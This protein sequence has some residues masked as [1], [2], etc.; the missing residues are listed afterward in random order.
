V[1]R[2]AGAIAFSRPVPRDL[3]GPGPPNWRHGQPLPD[4]PGNK[5]I[6]RRPAL[7][8]LPGLLPRAQAADPDRLGKNDKIFAESGARPYLRDLP[9]AEFHLFD[10]GHFLL[11]DKFETVAPMIH[12]FLDRKIGR[13]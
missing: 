6:E 3:T 9:N 4:R 5:D 10:S 1:P 13:R 7:P 12:D 11:E 8:G 2:S